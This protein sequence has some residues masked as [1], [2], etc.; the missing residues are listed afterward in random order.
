MAIPV[1]CLASRVKHRKHSEMLE[2]V[3]DFLGHEESR[4]P[5]RYALDELAKVV[6]EGQVVK[7]VGGDAA[8]TD[9]HAD[10]P[11]GRDC[12]QPTPPP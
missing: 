5:P 12:G 9:A 8:G 3:D 2:V 4:K 1:K 11:G 7:P 10:L 6:G